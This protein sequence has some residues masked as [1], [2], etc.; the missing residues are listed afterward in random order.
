VTALRVQEALRQAG[1]E[2]QHVEV[3]GTVDGVTISGTVQTSAERVRAE[4][5]ARSVHRAM[6][7]KNEVRVEK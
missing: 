7:L 4:E 6:K 5:I 3:N 1:A 2:F